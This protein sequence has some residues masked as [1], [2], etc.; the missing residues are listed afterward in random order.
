MKTNCKNT[1]DPTKVYPTILTQ[2]YENQKGFK[3]K[4]SFDLEAVFLEMPFLIMLREIK[5]KLI[6]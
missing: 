5:S 3:I 2:Y 1:L 6:Q 4:I